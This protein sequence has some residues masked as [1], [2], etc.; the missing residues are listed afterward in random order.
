VSIILRGSTSILVSTTGVLLTNLPF[1]TI[2]NVWL[3][4]VIDNNAAVSTGCGVLASAS[5]TT[6]WAIEARTATPAIF[7]QIAYAI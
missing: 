7:A 4:T 1:A 3:G 6:L 2:G 5:T